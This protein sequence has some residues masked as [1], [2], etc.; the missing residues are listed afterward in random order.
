VWKPAG[1]PESYYWL[2]IATVEN[3]NGTVQSTAAFLLDEVAAKLTPEEVE[4]AKRWIR[5]WKPAQSQH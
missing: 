1:A 5:H 4:E 3:N 2:G